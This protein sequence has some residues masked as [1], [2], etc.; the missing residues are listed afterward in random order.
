[1]VS[2]SLAERSGFAPDVQL[3]VLS[4]DHAWAV[5]YQPAPAQ[6]REAATRAIEH[7]ECGLRLLAAD[8]EPMRLCLDKEPV[9][10]EV[11][12]AVSRIDFDCDLSVVRDDERRGATAVHRQRR[13]HESIRARRQQLAPSRHRIRARSH[14]GRDHYPVTGHANVELPVDAHLDDQLRAAATKRRD[15]PS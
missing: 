15:L 10:L 14:R 9:D 11:E 12:A 8:R 5:A 13:A 3:L 1:M 6:P 7:D 4:C 2:G